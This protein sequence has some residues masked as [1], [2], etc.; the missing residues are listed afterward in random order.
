MIA[1]KLEHVGDRVAIFLD[2]EARAALHVVVGDTVQLYRSA[3]G[4]V[5]VEAPSLGFD[6]RH[7][8]GR[9]FLKRYQKSLGALSN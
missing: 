9:A 3:E 8:R 4:A 2:D 5:I 6:G 7:E 1:L